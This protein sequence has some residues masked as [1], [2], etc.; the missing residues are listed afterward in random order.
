MLKQKEILCKSRETVSPFFSHQI[1]WHN[2]RISLTHLIVHVYCFI[3]YVS[4][5]FKTHVIEK[6]IVLTSKISTRTIRFIFN[7][8]C[9]VKLMQISDHCDS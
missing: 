9:K 5:I 3:F 8:Q 6:M 1:S 7:H 2:L 4:L